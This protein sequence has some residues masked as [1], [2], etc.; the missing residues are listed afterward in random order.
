MRILILNQYGASDDAPTGKL[1][2][3][4]AEDWTKAGHECEFVSAE[5]GYRDRCGGRWGR[6]FCSLASLLWGGVSA[7]RADLIL[8]G[9]SP[10][11]V[12]VVAALAAAWHGAVLVH[13]AMDL[14]P[15]LGSRLAGRAARACAGVLQG[16]MRSAYARCQTVVTLDGDMVRVL[17]GYGVSARV[18]RPWV[19]GAHFGRGSSV[20][21]VPDGAGERPFFRWAYS[22]NLGRAHEWRTLLEAQALLEARGVEAELVFQGGGAAWKP[23]SEYAS[24]L[25]LRRC[26]WMPY[27]P[28]AELVPRL[29]GNDCLVATQLPEARGCLWPSKLALFLGMPRPVLWVGPSGG[30]VAKFLEGKEGVGCYACGDIEGVADWVERRMALGSHVAPVLDRGE[31]RSRGLE[32]WRAILDQVTGGAG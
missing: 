8:A 29:L 25:G 23:A 16:W 24:R 15:E 22:G 4:V 26:R 30:A 10:P 27:V 19:C 32:G 5:R 31:E 13:W 2:G 1:F 11:C 12:L 6:E 17:E 21:S 7:K 20:E 3:E 9:S 14:Y 18:I 28:E